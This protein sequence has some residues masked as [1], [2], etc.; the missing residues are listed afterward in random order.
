MAT[1]LYQNDLPDSVDLGPVVAI[2]CETM[3]LNPHRDRLCVVQMSG[4]DGDAHLVQISK[5][6]TEAPNL[7][8]MLTNP[9]VL[10]LFHYGRFDIAALYHRFGALT[11]PVYCTKIASRLVRTYTDRHGLKN[12]TQDLLGQ[13]ISKQQQMS[14]WGADTLTRAQMDYAASDVLHLHRLRDALDL[15]LAREG[16]SDLAQACFDFLPTRARLDLAGWP[17]TDIFAHS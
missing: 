10:K 17:D 3:G 6:Q 16:R 11:A 5:D 8:S 7:T 9:D 1:H 4:G 14:D 15:R 2:D 13:D 12:L